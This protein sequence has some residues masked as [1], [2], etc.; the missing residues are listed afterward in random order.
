M[1]RTLIFLHGFGVRGWFWEEFTDFFKTSEGGSFTRVLA[2][3][4]EMTDVDTLVTTTGD[5]IEQEASRNGGVSLIGHSLGGAVASVVADRLGDR[6]VRKLVCMATPFGGST[7][8][9]KGFLRFLIRHH[10]LPDFLTRPHFYSKQTPMA[11]QKSM[12]ARVVAETPALLDTL[13]ADTHFHTTLLTRR[14]ELPSLVVCS[15]ADRVVSL[16]QSAALA[17]AIGAELYVFPAE[18]KVA[19]DDFV[20]APVVR[21]RTQAVLARFLGSQAS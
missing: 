21:E 14:L 20:A 12:F 8:H 17:D 6:L 7:A 5:L 11:V 9:L 18:E 19:H 2:P 15:G 16:A 1:E 4:L 10:L 13:T 3:D